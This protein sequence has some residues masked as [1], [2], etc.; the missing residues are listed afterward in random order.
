M[1]VDIHLE[2]GPRVE[3]VPHETVL[4]AYRIVQEG[5]R[6]LRHAGAANAWVEVSRVRGEL[7][8]RVRDDGRGMRGGMP[9]AGGLGLVSMRERARLVGGTLRVTSPSR[10]GTSIEARLP[11]RASPRSAPPP[12]NP[13]PARGD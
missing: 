13:A 8:V 10:G 5:L 9:E 2:V 1:G 4:A 3:G 6:N 7:R 12:G 11:V